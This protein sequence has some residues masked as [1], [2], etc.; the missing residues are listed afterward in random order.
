MAER[1]PIPKRMRFEVFK[2]DSF[3]CQYC[4]EASP[5]VVLHCDH[6]KPV[7]EGGAT[8][9]LNLV[10][11]CN[12]CNLGK[13]AIQLDDMSAIERQ[14]TQIEEL[15]ERRLQLEMMLQWRDELAKHQVDEVQ[16]VCAAIGARSKF[17]PND[18]G[19]ISV[20]R[21]LRKYGLSETLAAMDEAFD[22]HLTDDTDRSWNFAFK[23]I[24]R[25]L[26]W[27][28]QEKTD[29]HIRKL[30]Y[31]QAILRN[32]WKIDDLNAVDALRERVAAG[33]DIAALEVAAKSVGLD[34]NWKDLDASAARIMRQAAPKIVEQQAEEEE[35]EE[36][37][38]IKE[39]IAAWHD[40]A[41]HIR[42]WAASFGNTPAGR[43]LA[44]LATWVT[45]VG[46]AN[47]GK[48]TESDA[49]LV[50]GLRAV[51]L[52]MPIDKHGLCVT[53]ERGNISPHF[54]IR[55]LSPRQA[56]ASFNRFGSLKLGFWNNARA[57]ARVDEVH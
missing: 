43:V 1:V 47:E 50:R 25:V 20:R 10:T 11:A 4:G 42:M 48:I 46:Y 14:R 28:E 24:A 15:N 21:W 51:G 30:L 29:P 41:W 45:G 35:Y 53:D 56:T 9:L 7:V 52:I 33:Y 16:V 49:R 36:A 17:I 3:K 26:S 37:T 32:R 22:L 5:Q 39:S 55:P 27:R 40:D 31:I 2:R 6:I 13:G 54:Q 18:Q 57:F 23:R 34:D 12:T 8:E 44:E 19:K 38:E